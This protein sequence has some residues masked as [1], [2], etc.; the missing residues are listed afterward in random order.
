MRR[1]ELYIADLIDNARAVRGYLDGVTRERWDAEDI[2]RDAVLYRM[3]LLGEIASALPDE[4]RDSYPE[5]AWRQ[6][7]AFRNLA[8]HKYFGVDWAVVW[9]SAQE[10]PPLLEKQVLAIISAEYPALALTYKPEPVPDPGTASLRD[11]SLPIPPGADF[12]ELPAS[13]PKHCP[14]L[15]PVHDRNIKIATR[16]YL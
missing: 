15:R 10:E 8:V 14:H 9:K 13:A 3:L 6:I 7:R 4:L 11:R 5:V 12:D 16:E 1:E 2:L